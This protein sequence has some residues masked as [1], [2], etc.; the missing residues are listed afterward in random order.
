MLQVVVGECGLADEMTTN[1]GAWAS[2]LGQS[3]EQLL[4]ITATGSE[5]GIPTASWTVSSARLVKTSFAAETGAVE[6]PSR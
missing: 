4:D 3:D 5:L 2:S 6:S 1:T